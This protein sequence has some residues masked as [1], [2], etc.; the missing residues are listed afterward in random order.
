[1]RIGE[2]VTFKTED[3]KTEEGEIVC[4]YAIPNDYDLIDILTENGIVHGVSTEN[5]V[6]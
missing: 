3:G 1:M 4:V 2:R 5:V 6:A